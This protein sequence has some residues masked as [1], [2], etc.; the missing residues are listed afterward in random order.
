MISATMAPAVCSAGSGFCIVT[1]APATVAGRVLTSD[2]RGVG[3]AVVTLFGEEGEPEITVT[4]SF[5]FF[6]FESVPS[7]AAYIVSVSA[8]GY[9]FESQFVVV[10]DSISDLTF[11]AAR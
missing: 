4:N 7:G 2:G 10:N 1:S 9:S 5:G 3:S 6:R 11:V 8:N